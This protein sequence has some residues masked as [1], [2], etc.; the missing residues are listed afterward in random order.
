MNDTNLIITIA[1]IPVTFRGKPNDLAHE[2][3]RRMKIVSPSGSNFI[4]IGDN[5][6]TSDVGPWLK[7]GNKWYV[8]DDETKRYV[9]QD[10]SDSETQWFQTGKNA[11]STFDP[12]VWLK[13][14]KDATED[15]PSIGNPISWHVHNG[16]AWVPFSGIVLS[17]PTTSRPSAPVEYQQYY[18][19]TIA[20]LIWWER[21][22]WRTVS[23][24]PGDIKFVAFEV[25]TEALTA[26]PGWSVFG[27][28]N[29]TLRGRWISQATKDAG[30]T[31]ETELTVGAG[32][33][34]RAAFET[35]GESTSLDL[36][37]GGGST[38]FPPTVALWCL[39]KD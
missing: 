28:S 1:Q 2:I 35:Y 39:Q 34:T 26:N 38:V 14:D 7:D 5:E 21:N 24:V 13:T 18:D 23:G 25:L 36:A 27:E 20:C 12:P 8:F 11:P 15:D 10:I 37:D 30:G 33:A 22:S 16:T 29:Q 3:V 32:V 31:P 9:P 19:T 17:G 6:P 4:F